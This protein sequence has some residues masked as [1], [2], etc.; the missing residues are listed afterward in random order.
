VPKTL[1]LSRQSD[2]LEILA[3]NDAKN[4]QQEH[5]WKDFA[6]GL[7]KPITFIFRLALNGRQKNMLAINT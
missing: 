6:D 2:L 4:I 3:E 1:S 5:L 7:T